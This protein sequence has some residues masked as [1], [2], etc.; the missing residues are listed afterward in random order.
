MNSFS[1]KSV[2]RRID[3]TQYGELLLD[4]I[5][6]QLETTDAIGD[7]M[8]VL[9]EILEDIQNQQ[10]EADKLNEETV[11]DCND[12]DAK[13]SKTISDAN[14]AIVDA[15]NLLGLLETEKARLEAE[16]DRVDGEKNKNRRDKDDAIF[17]RQDENRLYLERLAEHDESIEACKEAIELLEQLK[18][19]S[20]PSLIQI[21]KTSTTLMNLR[22]KIQKMDT[23][24]STY[25]PFL[26]VL[27]EIAASQENFANQDTVN[28]VA[29]LLNELQTD[30]ENSRAKL[31][32]DEESAQQAHDAYVNTLDLNYE[33]LLEK[34]RK[35]KAELSSAVS[36]I[37]VQK[38]I[39]S[40]NTQLVVDT[41]AI[42]DSLRAVCKEKADK[43][44]TE[45]QERNEE[46]EVV[47]EVKQI[48]AGMESEMN[49]YLKERV[50][51]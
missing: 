39:V 49:D 24:T 42:L 16:L 33:A 40:Y 41:Q 44:A 10:E 31:N 32:A 11:A 26:K 51:A 48:F 2:L 37:A 6:L 20:A 38:G 9:D 21:R 19:N 36:E 30:L 8:N 45:T 43:Y 35:L 23:I 50:N 12:K 22:E 18:N 47:D 3:S 28:Q 4:V 5:A 7:I 17:Q 1:A 25:T 29:V 27:L 34:E 46:I 15:T 14:K 13:Y